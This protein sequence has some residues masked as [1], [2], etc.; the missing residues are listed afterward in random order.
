MYLYGTHISIGVQ[1]PPK[2]STMVDYAERINPV[3]SP[4]A[5]LGRHYRKACRW[6]GGRKNLE[7]AKADLQRVG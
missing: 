5:M 6:W 1:V 7:E 2:L 4:D 3:T